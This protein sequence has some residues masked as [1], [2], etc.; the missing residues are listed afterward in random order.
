[1]TSTPKPV[2]GSGTN[3]TLGKRKKTRVNRGTYLSKWLD[4]TMHHV[5]EQ[6]PSMDT[7]ESFVN[8]NLNNNW[9]MNQSQFMPNFDPFKYN[10][11]NYTPEPVSLPT[12][13]TYTS[14]ML[15]LYSPDCRFVP[16]VNKSIQVHRPRQRRRA[17]NKAE[18]VTGKSNEKLDSSSYLQQK[19]LA[20]SQDFTSLPPIVTSV[21]DTTSNSDMNTNEKDDGSNARRYSD[22]CVRGLPDIAQATGADPESESEEDSEGSHVGSRLLGCLLDQIS[23]LKTAN[24]TLNRELQETKAELQSVRQQNA[25]WQKGSPTALG[26][27]PNQAPLN[28]NGLLG[29]NYSPGML[30][31]LVR[32]IRDATRVREESLYAR[33]RSM[34]LEQNSVVSN[35]LLALTYLEE[36]Q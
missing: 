19:N 33:I 9:Q 2:N 30:S 1:M 36:C 26:S 11:Y 16:S 8:N 14:P 32:E 35:C 24:E 7:Y 29:A 22:P 4:K 12:F 15:G 20:G 17:D 23:T 10:L 31:D 5:H 27:V 28:S 3:G 34:V 21:G 25:I 6:T 13:P 18:D